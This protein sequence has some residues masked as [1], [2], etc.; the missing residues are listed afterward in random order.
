MTVDRIASSLP[1]PVLPSL[2]KPGKN[3]PAAAASGAD[4]GGMDPKELAKA[5]EA[6]KGFEQVFLSQMFQQMWSTVKADG[7][8]SGGHGEE[9]FRSMV[10]D[11][12]ATQITKS[13]GI[14]IGD[15]LLGD[16]LKMQGDMSA[17]EIDAAVAASH[18]G[19]A[20]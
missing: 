2:G 6:A 4:I 7:P 17:Q 11:N 10:V 3:D 14:G 18:D 8:F 9:M 12:Y 19:T 13:G 20:L 1:A 5:R 16:M 15:R